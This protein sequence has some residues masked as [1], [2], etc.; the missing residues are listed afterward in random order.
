MWRKIKNLEREDR[1]RARAIEHNVNDPTRR[2][3]STSQSERL[4]T[5]LDQLSQV[6]GHADR[7]GPMQNNTKGLFFPSSAKC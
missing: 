1:S 7:I 6:A 3:Q 4:A 2:E 5:Y